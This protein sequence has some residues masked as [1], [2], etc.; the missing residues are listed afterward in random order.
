MKYNELK[1]EVKKVHNVIKEITKENEELK[2]IFC[3]TDIMY[4]PLNCKENPKILLLG[5][6]TGC[7]YFNENGEIIEDFEE[8]DKFEYIDGEYILANEF[9][10]LLKLCNKTDLMEHIIKSNVYYFGTSNVDEFKTFMKILN[11]N[12]KFQNIAK[13]ILGKASGN[14]LN[15]LAKRWTK[16]LIEDIVKPDFIIC[17]GKS[18]YDNLLKQFILYD[19]YGIQINYP[20]EKIIYYERTYSNIRNK[21]NFCQKLNKILKSAT[22]EQ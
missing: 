1:N 6:N 7:G 4:S 19:S 2:K 21:E 16:I 12:E 14:Y 9:K 5:Y 8:S 3:G 17:E 20:L 22:I 18:T 11:N 10:N 15:N 13:E